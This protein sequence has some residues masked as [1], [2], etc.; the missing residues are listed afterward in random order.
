MRSKG[1]RE[2]LVFTSEKHAADKA[3]ADRLREAQYVR[4]PADPRVAPKP[5]PHAAELA[6]QVGVSDGKAQYMDPATYT[7]H[8]AA[9]RKDAAV[10]YVPTKKLKKNGAPQLQKRK[11][12]GLSDCYFSF[13][14]WY[15]RWFGMWVEEGGIEQ[16]RQIVSAAVHAAAVELKKRTGYKV[17]GYAVH[18]DSEGVIGF[19]IQFQTAA[20][21][22]L[23]GRSA[24]GKKGG[25][26]LAGDAMSG[27]ARMAEYGP[28]EDRFGILDRDYD[29]LAINRVLDANLRAQMQKYPVFLA[30]IESWAEI[31]AM[32]WRSTRELAVK[33][34]QKA[35]APAPPDPKIV[36]LEQM[37]ALAEEKVLKG[38]AK[39]EELENRLENVEQSVF[40]ALSAEGDVTKDRVY[41]RI[42]EE[43][44]TLTSKP[45]PKRQAAVPSQ[46][47]DR[48]GGEPCL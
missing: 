29:D 17:V 10:W 27:V 45:A 20:A 6:C 44:N 12:E 34:R 22:K 1:A 32:I 7:Q 15:A 31:D 8:L 5:F 36:Q 41:A 11:G 38:Q 4:L 25:L 47:R 48:A 19:H 39:V 23:I 2:H 3:A 42:M 33:K 28:V 35:L 24:K 16:V 14:P 26:R 30:D 21:G 46:P 37:L 43:W 9:A 18:P 40:L 13:P